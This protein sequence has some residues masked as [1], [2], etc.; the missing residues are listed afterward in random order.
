M[1][2]SPAFYLVDM[3]IRAHLYTKLDSWLNL[4]HLCCASQSY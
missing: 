4:L 1:A 3:H 2:L